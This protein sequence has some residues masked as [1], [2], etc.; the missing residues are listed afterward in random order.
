MKS[1]LIVDDEVGARESLKMIL[2]N[3]YEV[4]LAKNAEEAFLQI[5]NH[6]PDV[7]LLD[8][9][10]PDLDGLK[11][12]EKIKQ[13]DPDAIVIMIT[14]TKTV[15]TAVEAMKLGAY[16]YV[17]KP[18]DVDELR[19]IISRALSTQALEKEVQYLREEIDKN[20]GFGNMIGKSK[21]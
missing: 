3:D 18:F 6:S 15:K 14:A 8:I 12:L 19:L 1:V 13:N 9:I 10:L 17:T 20:F 21:R 7:I 5:K 4:F 2:K 16:D 11:V